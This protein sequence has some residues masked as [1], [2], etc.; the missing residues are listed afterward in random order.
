MYSS[1]HEEGTSV[2]WE[3]S[4]SLLHNFIRK[5]KVTKF[6]DGEKEEEDGEEEK[7]KPGVGK[8]KEEE[9]TMKGKER[10]TS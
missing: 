5:Y 1:D 6:G 4:V 10:D 3:V 7:K 2:A 9:K 8:E